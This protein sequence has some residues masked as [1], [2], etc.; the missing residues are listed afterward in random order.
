MAEIW[1]LNVS[2]GFILVGYAF[3]H[4]TPHMLTS[5]DLKT[6]NF[7]SKYIGDA[8]LDAFWNK[9]LKAFTFKW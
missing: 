4:P 8:Q 1:H 7:Q 6:S 2:F 9:A 5:R 3:E